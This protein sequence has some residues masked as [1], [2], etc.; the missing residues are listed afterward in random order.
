MRLHNYFPFLIIY[1]LIIIHRQKN[2]Y[3]NHININTTY[4]FVSFMSEKWEGKYRFCK[5]N[6]LRHNLRTNKKHLSRNLHIF[7]VYSGRNLHKHKIHP[8][9]NL[10]KNY[11]WDAICSDPCFRKLGCRIQNVFIDNICYRKAA[12]PGKGQK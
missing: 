11:K 3:F 7:K 12:S 4:Y 1:F 9:H 6:F 8:S 10:H 5:N 2:Q